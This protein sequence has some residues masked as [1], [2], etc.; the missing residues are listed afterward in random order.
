MLACARCLRLAPDGTTC[1]ACGAEL[2]DLGSRRERALIED[3]EGRARD[4]RIA[5]IHRVAV[6]ASLLIGFPI[7]AAI[8]LVAL[9]LFGDRT[10]ADHSDAQAM[11]V[12]ILIAGVVVLAPGLLVEKL[13]D[14]RGKSILDDQPPADRP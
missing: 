12:A 4:R 1:A 14:R 13:S 8:V 6:L 9:H 7:G 5:R 2:F 10:R 3:A 11:K